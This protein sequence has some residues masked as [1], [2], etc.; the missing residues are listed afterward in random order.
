MQT[1]CF[2]P[3][4]SPQTGQNRQ[5]QLLEDKVCSAPSGTRDQGATEGLQAA[6][7]KTAAKL[8]K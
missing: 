6:V 5:I 3:S 2:S 7:S 1:P 4:G 8:G